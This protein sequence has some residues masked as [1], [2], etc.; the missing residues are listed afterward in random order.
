MYA[1]L[2]DSGTAIDF[3]YEEMFIQNRNDVPAFGFV[4][5]VSLFEAFYIFLQT[6]TRLADGFGSRR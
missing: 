1:I 6:P 2:Y 4:L 5:E 3:I